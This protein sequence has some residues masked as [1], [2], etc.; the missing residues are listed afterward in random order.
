M[1]V[2]YSLAYWCI[3]VLVYRRIAC[4]LPRVSSEAVLSALRLLEELIES[5]RIQEKV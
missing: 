1:L 5:M 3:G 2:V 4:S